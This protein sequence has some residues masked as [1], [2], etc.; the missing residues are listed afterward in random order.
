MTTV[1]RV[2]VAVAGAAGVLVVLSSAIRSVVL[3][4]AVPARLARV[5]FLAVRL[6]LGALAAG[7]TRRGRWRSRE[8]LLSLQG[9]FG[10]LAQLAT[11]TRLDG[12][13]T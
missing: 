13:I 6:P 4:K 12:A 3:P 2:L 5:A 1:L 7:H 11:W 8:N 10:I 9:P